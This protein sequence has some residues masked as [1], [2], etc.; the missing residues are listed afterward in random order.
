MND[1]RVQQLRSLLSELRRR[2]EPA[3]DVRHAGYNDAVWA[4]AVELEQQTALEFI[5]HQMS[6][7]KLIERVIRTIGVTDF[8]QALFCLN[9]FVYVSKSCSR[10]LP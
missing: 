4:R 8:C 5:Q 1:E 3:E 9:E 10:S 6:F 2:S 7:I